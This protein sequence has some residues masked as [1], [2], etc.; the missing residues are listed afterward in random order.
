MD[1]YV[2]VRKK[3]EESASHETVIVEK[4]ISKP[5]PNIVCTSD[6]LKQLIGNLTK[7]ASST[8]IYG[9]GDLSAFTLKTVAIW[10]EQAKFPVYYFSSRVTQL[11]QMKQEGLFY[12]PPFFYQPT[13]YQ[14]FCCYYSFFPP[15]FYPQ[16]TF[17]S[18]FFCHH[19]LLSVDAKP[20][21][22]SK[23]CSIWNTDPCLIIFDGFAAL[24]KLSQTSIHSQLL[25]SLERLKALGVSSWVLVPKAK[26]WKNLRLDQWDNIIRVDFPVTGAPHS[27]RFLVTIEQALYF[28]SLPSARFIIDNRDNFT[29]KVQLFGGKY[30]KFEMQ[31][32]RLTAEGR[33]G[34]EILKSL[35]PVNSAEEPTCIPSLSMLNRLKRQWG[36]HCN[37]R[38]KH[39]KK[40]K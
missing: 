7:T 25:I 4:T 13:F 27:R 6:F 12:R 3:S 35:Q 23:V 1:D 31:V 33:T 40:T 8:L 20:W 26:L 21:S 2:R 37:R 30:Q 19:L 17:Y 15:P 22:N 16:P 39:R 28:N 38:H 18:P 36:I 11:T 32:R 9:Q 29:S 34:P 14:P 24:E 5:R 10:A